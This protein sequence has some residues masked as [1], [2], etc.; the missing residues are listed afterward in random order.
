MSAKEMYDIALLT[1]TEKRKVRKNVPT[2][3][4]KSVHA[5]IRQT[6]RISWGASSSTVKHVSW[7]VTTTPIKLDILV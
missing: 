4:R 7:A 2:I 5:R 1:S 3:W 6:N